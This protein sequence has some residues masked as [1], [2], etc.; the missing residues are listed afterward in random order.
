[1]A[2]A[3]RILERGYRAYDGKRGG[4]GAAVRTTAKHSIQ[5]SLGLKRTIWQKI[6][7]ALTIGLVYIPAIVFVGITAMASRF[8]INADF[9]PTYV[10]YYGFVNAAIL[11]FSAFVAPEVLCTDRRSGMLGLYLASPL[12]RNTYLLAKT[13]GVL[14]ILSIV[15][16]GPVL[17]VLIGK[18]ILGA[19][20]DGFDGW[21]LTFG[22]II[23]GGLGIS[24]LY[25]SLSMVISS[26]TSRRAVA[27]AAIVIVLI[28]SA[29]AVGSLLGAG[30]SENLQA[31]DLFS[32]PFQL[33]YSI[34]G[35]RWPTEDYEPMATW[36]VVVANV[37]WTVLFAGITWWRYRK[38]TVTK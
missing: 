2:E 29:G 6:L 8:E 3:A 17:L 30:G 18:T 32:L 15:T 7:P 31:L 5:R 22:R 23:L 11:V 25:A 21:L 13:L 26:L 1:M 14:T 20:P 12:N 19:G 33:V 37:G 38:L 27:S 9:G 36:L 4:I 10:E 24:A 16:V 34:Y 28:A 35:D